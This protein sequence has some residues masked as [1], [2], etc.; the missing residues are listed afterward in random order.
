[1]DPGVGEGRE[2][3]VKITAASLKRILYLLLQMHTQFL[4]GCPGR[5][6]KLGNMVEIAT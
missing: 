4:A 6:H 2:N 5:K 1:M 3:K